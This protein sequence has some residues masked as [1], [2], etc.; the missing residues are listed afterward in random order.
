MSSRTGAQRLA[1]GIMQAKR[2]ETSSV[3]SQT[4]ASRDSEI[5]HSVMLVS[6]NLR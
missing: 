5:S 6:Y 1:S 3:P 4:G 2:R